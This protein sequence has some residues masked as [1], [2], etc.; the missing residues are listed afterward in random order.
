MHMFH[1]SENPYF[2]SIS[3]FLFYL[4]CLKNLTYFIGHKWYYLP[5]DVVS[6]KY[7]VRARSKNNH[8]V[9]NRLHSPP[10][11]YLNGEM[12]TFILHFIIKNRRKGDINF[13]GIE[14]IQMI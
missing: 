6:M 8:D 13:E 12:G 3:V 4:L 14:N 7:N 11:I 10:G 1:K 2:S 5:P 9:Q